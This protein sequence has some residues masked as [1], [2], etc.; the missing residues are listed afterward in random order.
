MFIVAFHRGTSGGLDRMGIDSRPIIA[1]D[2]SRVLISISG[3]VGCSHHLHGSNQGFLYVF[4]NQS[5]DWL[6]PQILVKLPY[7]L[8]IVLLKNNRLAPAH[9][10]ID[11]N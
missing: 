8:F 6:Y 7:V 1:S 3:H 2:S 10:L 4:S 9:D 11:G 5:I